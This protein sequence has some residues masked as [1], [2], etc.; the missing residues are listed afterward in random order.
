[1]VVRFG[2]SRMRDDRLRKYYGNKKE[3]IKGEEADSVIRY[4]KTGT[5][6]KPPKP[7]QPDFNKIIPARKGYHGMVGKKSNIFD[8]SEYFEGFNW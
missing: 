2:D 4:Y 3:E 1:M 5:K 7:E 6:I 8:A